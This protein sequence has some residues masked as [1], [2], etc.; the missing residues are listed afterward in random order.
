METRLTERLIGALNAEAM[1]LADEARSWFDEH[2]RAARADLP[3]LVQ[4]G[5]SCEALKVTTRLMQVLA[6]L[7]NRRAVEAGEISEAQAQAPHNRLG[8]VADSDPATLAAL[9]LDAI[10]LIE[11]SRDLFQRVARL[12]A[13][14]AR[15]SAEQGP[16]RGLF[17]RLEDAF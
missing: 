10:A 3:P 9:P 13:G 6:W 12:E 14:L 5:L 4:V 1:L 17:R 15:P 8:E 11:A 16:A 7:L 2:A